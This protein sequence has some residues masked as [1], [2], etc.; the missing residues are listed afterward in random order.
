[1]GSL[2]IEIQTEELPPKALKKLSDAFAKNLSDELR[3]QDFLEPFSVVTPFGS[4][5]RLATLISDVS[6]R[7]PDK[8]FRQKLVPVKVGLDAEGK[9]TAVLQKKL[10]ALHLDVKPSD[11]IVVNDG[12]QDQLVYDGVKPGVKL[13]E[14]LQSTLERTIKKLP[15]PKMMT[16]QLEDGST[17]EF[18]RPVKHVVALYDTEV[19]PIKLFGLESGRFTRG[20]RFHTKNE[21]E[22][23]G[24]KQYSEQLILKGK[25]MP[26]FPARQHRMV[27]ELKKKAESLNSVLIMPEDLVEEVAALTEWPVV[28]E[29]IF[30]REF[31]SVPEEC[32]ILTMQQNQ[33]YFAL[34]DKNGKLTNRFLV[35]SQIEAKDGGKAISEGNTRVVRARLADAKFF[36]DQD[37]QSTLESRVPGLEHVVYHNKLGNQLER[38]ERVRKISSRIAKKIG[39]D[40]MMAERAAKLA[41]ADLR[42]LMVGEFPELQGIMG[43]YYAKHDREDESVA[44]AIK[45]HYQPRFA[46]DALPST[47]VSLSV[48]LADKIETLVGLFGVGQLP[49][50][51]KDPFAL[52]RHALGIL[53]MLVEKELP[54][55]LDELIQIGT[56]EESVVPT[57]K[58]ASKELKAFFMD[59]LRVMLRDQG[60]SALEIEAVI[61]TEP[62]LLLDVPRR[63]RAVRQFMTLPE[64]D[65][66]AAANKRIE[67]ILKKNAEKLTDA[68][69]PKLFSEKEEQALW[70]ALQK[71]RVEV[72][73]DYLS[74]RYEAVLKALAPLKEPV[75]KFFDKVMV[76]VE[77]EKVRKNRLA[78]LSTLH[79]TMNQVAKLSC[80]AS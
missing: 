32:L 48:A 7:S 45:E 70:D 53:R 47:R 24:A 12:K 62:D 54:I 4:P 39:A 68:V 8:P 25:V 75:D 49:T 73:E 29:S 41:K 42:T 50:G 78:L 72:D 65:S 38:S 20:H 10:A 22:I 9:P 30:D 46:G 40:P 59:R 18:V 27:E 79:T 57:V 76:N 34:R 55:S 13:K 69:N 58:D 26:S 66:L 33:K 71:V 67:N 6:E 16:Y 5:R 14:A 60:Y 52:R 37:R 44:L 51:D 15:I 43:E 77:D 31:L 11:L 36:Y 2:L 3:A 28:Y 80:L 63:L 61:Q 35:V 17:V 21:I 23:D 1:M 56:E 74:G 19:L 64:A